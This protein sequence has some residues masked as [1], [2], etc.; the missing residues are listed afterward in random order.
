MFVDFQGQ[1]FHCCHIAEVYHAKK[2]RNNDILQFTPQ[3]LMYEYQNRLDSNPFF[4][5]KRTCGKTVNKRSPMET[6]DTTKIGD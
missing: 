3:Q 1:E 4:V 2:E 6:R 5:C